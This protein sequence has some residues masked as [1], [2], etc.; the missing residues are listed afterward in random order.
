M[1]WK[2]YFFVALV[3]ALVG[4]AFPVLLHEGL[5]SMA[6]WEWGYVPLYMAQILGLFGFV[7][8][9]RLG[10]PQ[11]WKFVFVASIVL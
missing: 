1:W 10:S 2:T 8:W 3:L 6:W 5:N 11:I 4:L 7:F 9:R